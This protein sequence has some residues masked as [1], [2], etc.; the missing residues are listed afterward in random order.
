MKRHTFNIILFFLFIAVIG[1]T[2]TSFWGLSLSPKIEI[3]YRTMPDG[4]V[5]KHQLSKSFFEF[6]SF[7]V[8]FLSTFFFAFVTLL[9]IHLGERRRVNKTIKNVIVVLMIVVTYSPLVSNLLL[10]WR[11]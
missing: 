5:L 4:Q 10:I 11:W 1:D 7:F 8:P 3:E 6:N 2:L 9:V